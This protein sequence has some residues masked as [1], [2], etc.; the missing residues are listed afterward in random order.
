MIHLSDKMIDAFSRLMDVFI[1]I[2][3]DFF[4]LQGSDKSFSIPVLPRASAVCYRNRNTLTR[5]CREIST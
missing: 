5:E 3:V 2:E 4:L 1:V